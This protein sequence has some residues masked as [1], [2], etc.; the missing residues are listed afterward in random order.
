MTEVADEGCVEVDEELKLAKEEEESP[1]RAS[2][3][4][5]SGVI[6]ES[7]ADSLAG[8]GRVSQYI[9]IEEPP[10]GPSTSKNK[11]PSLLS[12]YEARYGSPIVSPVVEI[13]M[14]LFRR[15]IGVCEM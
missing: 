13:T 2:I 8:P 3:A 6:E 14:L 10:T 4:S 12:K 7:R 5:P 15:V 9:S 11:T 1:L